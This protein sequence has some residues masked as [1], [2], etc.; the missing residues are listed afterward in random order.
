MSH[1]KFQT[2]VIPDRS[3]VRQYPGSPEQMVTIFYDALEQFI[4][5]TRS[6]T[7]RKIIIKLAKYVSELLTLPYTE[8]K[9]N[10]MVAD[11][12]QYVSKGIPVPLSYC[13]KEDL[14]TCFHRS[15]FLQILFQEHEIESCIQT[16]FTSD[17]VDSEKSPVPIEDYMKYSIGVPSWELH[18]WN[19]AYDGRVPL[20][21]DS[22]LLLDKKPS[23]SSLENF[24]YK[25]ARTYFRANLGDGYY[26]H[27]LGDFPDFESRNTRGINVEA[28]TE[29]SS[30]SLRTVLKKEALLD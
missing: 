19:I 1:P 18:V 17:I 11:W 5:P 27:N 22:S 8:T 29:K 24:E 2:L 14:I 25:S 30:R 26:I 7:K 6:Y 23:I 12:E 9:A 13:I 28:L 3:V 16:G 10:K 21:V 4:E 15:V 20:Y